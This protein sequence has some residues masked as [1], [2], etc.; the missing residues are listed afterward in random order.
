MSGAIVEAR[1]LSYTYPDGTVALE[2]VSFSVAPGEAVALVGP[3][4]AGKST[5]LH[6]LIWL[7]QPQKGEVLIAGRQVSKKTLKDVRAQVGLI[8][9]NPDDQLF[10][11]TLYDDVA[12]GPLNRGIEGEEL[13]KRVRKAIADRG[14][15][16][17]EDKFPGHLSGGQKRLASLAAVLVLEPAVLLLDEPSTNLDPK[18]RRQLIRQLDALDS[19]RIIA[20]HD[21]EMALDLCA[22]A[23]LLDR[24]R[25][26]AEGDPAKLLADAALMEARGLEVPH[27][28]QPHRHQ[29][30]PR[31]HRDG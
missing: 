14:L 25:L 17:M 18:S 16:G 15:A 11:P 21:L 31:S 8:F 22:R 7:L 20:S 1:G 10:M 30:V 13:D 19:A 23:I 5:L 12:F 29:H 28:L 9:Q 3:S 2:E 26:V 24:G 4:G 27:S 6:C